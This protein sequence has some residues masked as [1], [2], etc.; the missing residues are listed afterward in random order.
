MVFESRSSLAL[1]CVL[2]EEDLGVLELPR[3][4]RDKNRKDVVEWEAISV[5]R[6][7]HR[8]SRSEILY[9]ECEQIS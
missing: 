7:L 5:I 9:V 4:I 2:E 1:Q 8:F 3:V 6:W